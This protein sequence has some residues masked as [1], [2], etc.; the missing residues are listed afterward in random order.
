MEKR[1]LFGSPLATGLRDLFLAELKDIYWAEKALMK[2]LPKMRENASSE[3]LYTAIDEHLVETENQ[4]SRLEGVFVSLGEKPEG[5]KCEAME[6]LIMEAEEMM[7][8]TEKGPLRD[9]AIISCAQKVEHYEIASYGTLVA[10]AKQLKEKEA[11]DLLTQTL[12]EEKECDMTLTQV[13]ETV[14]NLE[15]AEQEEGEE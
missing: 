4:V 1:G 13:A 15:A 2:A 3:E 14:V 5:E 7:D 6:G 9:A 8:Q 10:F 12:I 11:A